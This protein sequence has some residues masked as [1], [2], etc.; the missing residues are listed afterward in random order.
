MSANALTVGLPEERK[1]LAERYTI[2]ADEAESRSHRA[3][4]E[5]RGREAEAQGRR[6]PEQ[7]ARPQIG[8]RA[9]RVVRAEVR[10]EPARDEPRRESAKEEPVSVASA[11]VDVFPIYGWLQ[12]AAPPPD[13]TV[14]WTR[15]LLETQV[16][17]ERGE[18]P[19]V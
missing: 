17:K 14:D 4:D 6:P 11:T 8:E 19:L 1:A 13:G 18:T 9:P 12:Q 7:R 10:R 5:V 3:A 16:E 15:A 2:D